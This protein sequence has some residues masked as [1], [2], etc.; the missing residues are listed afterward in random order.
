MHLCAKLQ[1]NAKE[2]RILGVECGVNVQL[3]QPALPFLKSSLIEFKGHERIAYK[4]DNKGKSIGFYFDREQDQIKIYDK[5]LQYNKGIN[6]MRFEI[7]YTRMRPL[8]KIFGIA[9][10]NSHLSLIQLLD[11]E[12]LYKLKKLLL[13]AWD[14]ILL[15][16]TSINLAKANIPAKE[17]QLLEEGRSYYYWQDLRTQVCRNVWFKR[18][19]DFRT[20]LRKYGN[21]EHSKIQ[22]LISVEWEMLL[23]NKYN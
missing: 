15:Y 5:A 13:R 14:N 12:K 4:K 2:S 11:I 1:V 6:L 23:N 20:L 10:N 21:N 16:D 18:K 3:Q 19:R 22:E 9:K 8:K 17:K 7:K